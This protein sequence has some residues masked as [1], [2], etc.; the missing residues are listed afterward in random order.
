MRERIYHL[1]AHPSGP[2]EIVPTGFSPL[3]AVLGGFWAYANGLLGRYL[4]LTAAGIPLIVLGRPLSPVFV[5]LAGAYWIVALLYYFPSRASAWRASGL[6]QQGFWAA[7]EA[8]G[9]FVCG[10]A[11][12][13][14]RGRAWRR[15][16]ATHWQGRDIRPSRLRW[17]AGCWLSR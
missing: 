12:K 4:L 14:R 7:G 2:Y 17:Q 9:H 1:Y 11:S 10:C 6:E 8:E 16:L 15:G 5:S 13:V 3:A